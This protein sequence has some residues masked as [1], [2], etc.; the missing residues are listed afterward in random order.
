MVFI[1]FYTLV[2]FLFLPVD[3]RPPPLG[4][5]SPFL[6]TLGVPPQLP[7]LAAIFLPF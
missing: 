6:P 4:F 3:L 1:N 7:F 2:Y 5:L